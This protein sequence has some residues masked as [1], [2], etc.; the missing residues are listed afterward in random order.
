MLNK[1]LQRKNQIKSIRFTNDAFKYREI[2]ANQGNAASPILL[3]GLHG[4]GSNEDQMHTLVNLEP[5]V[6][7]VYVSLR[8]F[9]PLDDGFTWMPFDF[10]GSEVSIETAVFQQTVSRIA[11]FIQAMQAHYQIAPETTYIIGY[12]LGAGMS[13]SVA[14]AH[15]DLIHGAAVLTG[16]LFNEA[17]QF[18]K[19]EQLTNKPIF[20]GYGTLDPLLTQTDMQNMRIYLSTVGANITY[21]EYRIPHVVSKAERQDVEKWLLKFR[22]NLST[23]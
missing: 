4:H 11:T 7:F 21:H 19:T 16:Q 12:S 9:L 20:I 13:L 18:T 3:I 10:A 1:L 14:L 17:H 23:V 6:P 15:P 22:T 2:H 5:E 8:G